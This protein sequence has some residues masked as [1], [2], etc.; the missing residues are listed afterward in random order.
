MINVGNFFALA[1]AQV[2]RSTGAAPGPH[3]AVLCDLLPESHHPTRPSLVTEALRLVPL[4]DRLLLAL[5]CHWCRESPALLL[6]SY[7]RHLM[8]ARA[9]MIDAG[10]ITAPADAPCR[11]WAWDQ[12]V[13]RVIGTNNAMVSNRLHARAEPV[14]GPYAAEFLSDVRELVVEPEGAVTPWVPL[15]PEQCRGLAW[16]VD[17]DGS[18]GGPELGPVV[19]GDLLMEA[20]QHWYLPALAS[21]WTADSLARWAGVCARY[22]AARRGA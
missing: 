20:D 12:A 16:V 22:V 21:A 2:V 5:A 10:A 4:G 11:T 17:D 9:R 15:T 3:D 1:R 14:L 7:D 18:E 8:E 19:L 6:D 13:R